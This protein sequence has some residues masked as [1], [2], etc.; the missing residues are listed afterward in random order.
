MKLFPYKLFM[1]MIG[2][3]VGFKL[4]AVFFKVKHIFKLWT[5]NRFNPSLLFIKVGE[6]DL[7]RLTYHFSLGYISSVSLRSNNFVYRWLHFNLVLL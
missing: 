3:G 5:Y 1:I 6:D 7:M 4:A 2:K